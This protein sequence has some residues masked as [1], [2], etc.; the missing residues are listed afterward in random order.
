MV[1]RLL[2]PDMDELLGVRAVDENGEETAEEDLS[3]AATRASKTSAAN[4]VAESQLVHAIGQK[5][6]AARAAGSAPA[7][8]VVAIVH[9]PQV[10]LAQMHQSGSSGAKY[11]TG[12]LVAVGGG[13][14][15]SA[16]TLNGMGEADEESSGGM[17]EPI[18]TASKPELVVLRK[19][20]SAA[21]HSVQHLRHWLGGW[22]GGC[23]EGS[24]AAMNSQGQPSG[25]LISGVPTDRM[26]H[27]A[28]YPNIDADI[29]LELD[30]QV[31]GACVEHACVVH[32]Y[33]H[34]AFTVLISC[35]R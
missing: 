1:V 20:C 6:E 10:V 25:Q 24:S 29:T 12:G 35:W 31:S 2:A 28:F 27:K 30:R 4:L 9:A 32:A 7:M 11:D 19:M 21:G 17:H 16:A 3:H 26:W 18:W 13:D 22:L 8:Y 14:V 34:P 5:F 33:S 23:A 15:A